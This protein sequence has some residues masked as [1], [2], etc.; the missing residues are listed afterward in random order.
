[1]DARAM[2]APADPAFASR[3]RESFA[4]QKAMTLIGARLTIVDPATSRSSFPGGRS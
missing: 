3:C 2:N 4:R 1:M